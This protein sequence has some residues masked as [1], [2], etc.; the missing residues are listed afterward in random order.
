MI[1]IVFFA[2]LRESLGMDHIDLSL[3]SGLSVLELRNLLISQHPKWEMALTQ[4]NILMSVNQQYA[5]LDS[6][7]KAGDEVAFFP[8]VT[9]G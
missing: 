4:K 7:V 9:G 6:L 1:R 2:Q 3:D 8:P 5:S